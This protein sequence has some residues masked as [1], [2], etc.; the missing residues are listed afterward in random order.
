[1]CNTWL[2]VKKHLVYL[3]QTGLDRDFLWPALCALSPSNMMRDQSVLG[4]KE[5]AALFTEAKHPVQKM[6][7]FS[8][9][10]KKM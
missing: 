4:G 10:A 1:M 5:N 9:H 8:V 6:N 7:L 2:T 3:T